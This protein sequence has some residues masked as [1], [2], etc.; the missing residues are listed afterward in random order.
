MISTSGKTEG[1][2][3]ESCQRKQIPHDKAVRNDNGFERDALGWA[4]EYAQQYGLPVG[5]RRHFRR[6]FCAP[7]DGRQEIE[8]RS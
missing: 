5:V 1:R 2:E 6:T 4:L 8:K 3:Q 7:Q